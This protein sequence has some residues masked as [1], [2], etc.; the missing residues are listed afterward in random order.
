MLRKTILSKTDNVIRNLKANFEVQVGLKFTEM[1][2]EIKKLEEDQKPREA[3]IKDEF[4]RLVEDWQQDY[5][6]NITKSLDERISNL[7]NELKQ[8]KQF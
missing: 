4:R 5:N 8:L 6:Q 2:A 7:K 3:R 1:S